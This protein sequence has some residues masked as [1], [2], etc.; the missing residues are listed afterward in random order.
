VQ[1]GVFGVDVIHGKP[2]RLLLLEVV[3]DVHLQGTLRKVNTR[4]TT[5]PSIRSLV[6]MRILFCS[7]P[8]SLKNHTARWGLMFFSNLSGWREGLKKPENP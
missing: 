3:R 5:S 2:Q 7:R 6:A 8:K 1:R 4:F